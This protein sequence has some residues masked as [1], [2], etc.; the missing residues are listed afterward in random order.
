MNHKY[1]VKFHY[2]KYLYKK[3]CRRL[4][5]DESSFW[6][7]HI[8]EH[9]QEFKEIK[10]IYD[11]IQSKLDPE[12]VM[13]AERRQQDYLKNLAS[14]QGLSKDEEKHRELKFNRSQVIPNPKPKSTFM[15]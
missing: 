10:E 6:Y 3:V 5:H 9:Q 8:E 1:S 2:S 4:E 14:L 12:Q 7:D 15:S 11:A 13:T